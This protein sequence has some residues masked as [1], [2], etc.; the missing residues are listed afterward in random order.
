MPS[1]YWFLKYNHNL[2][3][4]L[5]R[6]LHSFGWIPSLFSLCT[7]KYRNTSVPWADTG[8][9]TSARPG[10]GKSLCGGL[11]CQCPKWWQQQRPALMSLLS[12]GIYHCSRP[13]ST[14]WDAG[15]CLVIM[16]GSCR[17]LFL[18][19]ESQTLESC[20]IKQVKEE[21][22]WT[23]AARCSHWVISSD[24]H[25]GFSPW[26]SATQMSRYFL[27]TQLRPK[28]DCPLW[29]WGLHSIQQQDFK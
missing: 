29:S 17:L 25:K 16:L 20:Q 21:T 15:L 10:S 1:L 8:C 9:C 22:S 27:Y 23:A 26:F 18:V 3:A 6:C 24:S 11:R 14:C 5:R 4:V 12:Q 19:K 7:F 28:Y 2:K 13:L